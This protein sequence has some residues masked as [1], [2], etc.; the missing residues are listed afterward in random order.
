MIKLKDW[1]NR[2]WDVNGQGQTFAMI[3]GPVDFLMG[4]P[5]S[6][7]SRSIDEPPS[8]SISPGFGIAAKEV[9]VAEYQTVHQTI[10]GSTRSQSRPRSYASPISGRTR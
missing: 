6:E 1:G 4:S 10:P 8:S 2:R 3:E 9:S 7:P 5:F